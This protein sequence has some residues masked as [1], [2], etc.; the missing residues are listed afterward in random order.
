MWDA[1]QVGVFEFYAGAFVAIIQ[2]N[3]QTRGDQMRE[4]WNVQDWDVR[5]LSLP[6]SRSGRQPA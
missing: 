4:P 2:Q 1:N 5:N 3:I 6:V